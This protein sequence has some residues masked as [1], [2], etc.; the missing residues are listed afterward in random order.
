MTILRLPQ[1]NITA[2]TEEYKQKILIYVT[3]SVLGITLLLVIFGKSLLGFATSN[4]TA[5]LPPY[6]LDYLVGERFTML[7]IDAIKAMIYVSITALALYFALKK[8]LSQ[9]IALIIIGLVS[10]FDLWS[11]NKAIF[12][13]R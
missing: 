12:Q 7:R 8:K 10:L 13:Q 11:V 2:M 4:E 6:L 5:Y 3:G 9:N 1:I